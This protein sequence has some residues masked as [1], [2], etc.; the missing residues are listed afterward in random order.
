MT[1]D[2]WMQAQDREHARSTFQGMTK[3]WRFPKPAPAIPPARQL[4]IA[5]RVADKARKGG[6]EQAA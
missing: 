1:D 4:E 2:E 5:M 3:R 6:Q